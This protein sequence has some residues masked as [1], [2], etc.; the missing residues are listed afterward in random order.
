MAV[1]HNTKMILW[2]VQIWDVAK[3]QDPTADGLTWE[4]FG[5]CF[6]REKLQ[7]RG[8]VSS[9]EQN[10]NPNE[11]TT[12]EAADKKRKNTKRKDAEEAS[13]TQG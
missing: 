3:H 4:T 5:A 8:D 1:H 6:S 13:V 11:A 12:G 10:I 9:S 2:N 7:F